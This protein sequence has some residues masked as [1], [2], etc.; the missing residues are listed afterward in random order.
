MQE[1]QNQTHPERTVAAPGPD[2]PPA[3]VGTPGNPLPLTDARMMRA[4][5]H[6]ARIAIWQHLGLDGPAARRVQVTV[7]LTPWFPP[8]AEQENADEPE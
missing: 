2:Q 6:P 4:L 3:A 8:P 5:A 7:D 1:G